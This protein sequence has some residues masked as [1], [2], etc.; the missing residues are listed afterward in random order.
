MLGGGGV[1]TT[2]ELGSGFVYLPFESSF[3]RVGAAPFALGP[4]WTVSFWFNSLLTSSHARYAFVDSLGNAPAAIRAGSNEVGAAYASAS[5]AG[6]LN[7]RRGGA[8]HHE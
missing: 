3:F 8:M 6:A 2:P 5:G 4:A 7:V 1:L